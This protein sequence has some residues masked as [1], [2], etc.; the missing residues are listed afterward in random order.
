VLKVLII[1][2]EQFLREG[3]KLVIDWNEY[4]YEICGE[5]ENGKVG[6]KMIQEETPDLVVIDMKMP[7][8]T[9]LEVIEKVRD[10]R[11]ECR[12]IILTGYADF[13]YAVKAIANKVD[14]YLLKP[15]DEEQLIKAIKKIRGELEKEKN[16]HGV[17]SH[18][19]NVVQQN[20]IE[21]LINGE[22]GNKHLEK[23]KKLYEINLEWNSY[24]I[25]IININEL[26]D[27]E[28]A[29]NILIYKKISQFVEENKYGYCFKKG[30]II[31]VLLNSLESDLNINY[32]KN[33]KKKLEEIINGNIIFAIG[34]KVY[35]QKDI[36]LSYKNAYKLFSNRFI[37][38]NDEII[39][40]EL[41]IKTNMEEA[42]SSK[43]NDNVYFEFIDSLK[44][45]LCVSININEHEKI[46]EYLNIL[47]NN[48]IKRFDSEN[49]IKLTYINFYKDI[50]NRLNI[51]NNYILQEFIQP[52]EDVINEINSKTTLMQLSNYIKDILTSISNHIIEEC[53]DAKLKKFVN[54]IEKNSEKELRLEVLAEM[55]NYNSTYLGK[56]FKNYTGQYFNTFLHLVRIEKA[57]KLLNDGLKVSEAAKK[58]G[59]SNIDYFYKN[60]KKYAGVSPSAYKK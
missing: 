26:N 15:I 31:G 6:L 22:I 56:Q 11:I 51:E 25:V 57:K 30:D 1:D 20:I 28:A 23:Y 27:D 36:V 45:N 60:F 24:Q 43:N 54:Y 52:T 4:G 53:H 9:G 39:T 8:M 41:I 35:N 42:Q 3:L 49:V 38:G 47:N 7:G 58:V 12:F 32:I 10:L 44:E 29:S 16:Q 14:D 34:K 37:F 21:N 18:L 5:A 17:M 55:F 59:Y 13:D 33:F 40:D 50:V 2:D 48:F 19:T 46:N